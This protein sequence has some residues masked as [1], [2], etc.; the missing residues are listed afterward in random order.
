MSAC[1]ANTGTDLELSEGDLA[2]VEVNRSDLRVV[3]DVIESVVTRRRDG[4][5]MV[6]AVE[7]E[8][9]L[10]DARVLPRYVVDIPGRGK[11]GA[12]RG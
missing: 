7:G 6:I 2:E 1:C 10:L 8:D 12:K 11:A 3:D 5:D 9:G 4:D